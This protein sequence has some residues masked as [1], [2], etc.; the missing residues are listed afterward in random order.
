[1]RASVKSRGKQ[2]GYILLT[3]LWMGLGLLLAASTFLTT[4]R[5][6]ALT[7]RAE[8]ET[9]R[10][11]E[12]VKSGI[13]VAMADLGRFGQNI[14]QS[15][16]DGTPTTIQMA[17]GAVEYRIYDENGKIDVNAA[18][19]ELL[20]PALEAVGNQSG[21]DAFDASNLTDAIIANRSAL[22]ASNGKSL[23]DLLSSAG[24][25]PA[26]VQIAMRYLTAHNFTPKINPATASRTVLSVIPGLGVGDVEDIIVRRESGRPMPRTGSASVWLS[27]TE[28]PIF[29]IEAVSRLHSGAVARMSV[30]VGGRGLTFRGGRT[31]FD[32]L[33][34]HIQR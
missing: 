13:N 30:V 6:T 15:R 34:A 31:R 19:V 2:R 32:V 10:A 24:L 17:E 33:S 21:F 12:L 29:T 28:G 23:F 22:E 1:M 14:T 4:Q 5:D 3:V 11:V 18:P 20:R 25:P 27:E 26:T 9:S 8:I 7:A 16:R